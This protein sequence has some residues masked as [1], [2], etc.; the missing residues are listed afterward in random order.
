VC[1]YTL[2]SAH[3]DSGCSWAVWRCNEATNESEP[4]SGAAPHRNGREMT[5][6]SIASPPGL[7]IAGWV[8]ANAVRIGENVP[9]VGAAAAQLSPGALFPRIRAHT[10]AQSSPTSSRDLLCHVASPMAG[11]NSSAPQ[12]RVLHGRVL[13]LYLLELMGLDNVNIQQISNKSEKTRNGKRW[14]R[15]L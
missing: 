3:S 7:R 2:G 11:F 13:Q 1:L 9:A 12:V 8:G 15:N 14:G 4:D 10:T 5:G 6:G